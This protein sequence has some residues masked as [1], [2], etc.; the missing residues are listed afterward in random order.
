MRDNLNHE[1]WKYT[2]P[3]LRPVLESMAD[4]LDG[5]AKFDI[6]GGRPIARFE[7]IDKPSAHY[8]VGRQ[9]TAVDVL[10]SGNLPL[11]IMTACM[12][13]QISGVG[14]YG[15]V[16]MK[17]PDKKPT[18]IHL[19]IKGDKMFW[20]QHPHTSAK[21]LYPDAFFVSRL[22]ELINEYMIWRCK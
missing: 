5:H 20:I 15:N 1:D 7:P 11:A 16:P 12:N 8:A 10:I 9:S 6:A 13:P 18:Y 3:E 21:I 17:N 14:I 4:A 2:D 22:N 19:E